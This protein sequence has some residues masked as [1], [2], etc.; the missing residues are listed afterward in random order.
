MKRY[1][2]H[3]R[4]SQEDV[5]DLIGI[6]QNAYSAMETGRVD[7]D[8]D[9]AEAI[10]KV[11][12]IRFF[13]MADPKQ[14]IPKIEDLPARTRKRVLERKAEGKKQRD[15][16]QLPKYISG[17]FESGR[18]PEKFSSFDVLSALPPEI[19]KKVKPARITD[20]F[21]KG[22]LKNRVEDTGEKNGR[23]KLYRLR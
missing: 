12:G 2:K 6:K 17:V 9:K 19:Q 1:R 16:L 21:K 15:D 11:Y 10:S 18:L 13:Q 3:Y 14:K 4:L 8:L 20:L 23:V 7:V 22:I 5:A